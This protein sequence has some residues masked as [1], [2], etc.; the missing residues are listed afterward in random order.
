MKQ[1][2]ELVAVLPAC[3]INDTCTNG[4]RLQQKKK[5][6]ALR[7]SDSDMK[8][9]KSSSRGGTILVKGTKFLPCK[10]PLSEMHE[11]KYGAAVFTPEMLIQR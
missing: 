5:K 6:M 9:W 8:R 11:A 7:W 4:F 2:H 10:V 1:K 3:L